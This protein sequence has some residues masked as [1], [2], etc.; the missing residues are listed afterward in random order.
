MA[1]SVEILGEIAE[2]AAE[3]ISQAKNEGQKVNIAEIARFYGISRLRIDR[4]LRGRRGRTSRKPVNTKLSDV[5]EA[6]LIR[7]IRTLDKAGT[8]VRIDQLTATAN[9]ILARDYT[10]DDEPPTVSHNWPACFL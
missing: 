3:E 2:K 8:S 7:Y 5:Q 4:R 10:K 9:R 1:D 6:A